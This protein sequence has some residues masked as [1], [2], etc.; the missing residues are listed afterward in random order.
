LPGGLIGAADAGRSVIA[1]ATV[2][3]LSLAVYCTTWTFYGSVGRAAA[4][5]IGFLP[6]YLGPTLMLALGWF[7]LHK[8]VR[9]AKANRITSIA[10]FVA[11][12]YGKSHLLGG[13]VTVIA[14]GWRSA[15]HR[16]PAQRRCPTASPFCCIILT[17]PCAATGRSPAARQCALCGDRHG[18]VYHPLWYPPP[19]CHR[20]SRG[21]VA[22]I[23]FESVVKLIAFFAVGLFVT[24]SLHDGLAAI[25]DQAELVPRLAKLMVAGDSA[26]NYGSW[27]ALTFLS[28][29]SVLLLPRQF[30]IAVVEN[31]NPDHLRPRVWLFPSTCFL[32]N[33]FV[34]P[35]ALGG[36]L[37]FPSGVD[38]DTF[39]LTLPM[40]A[41]G[42][43]LALFVFIAASRRLLAWSWWK[44]LPCP[45]WSA[46]DW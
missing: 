6:I 43:S 3:S 11:S 38:A 18:G 33:I 32:I 31:V 23:A 37:R 16:S 27:A 14:V 36:L 24:Y 20:A 12:R 5:G 13:L 26:A 10:D 41:Q 8:M 7:V 22:A 45:P 30:Q 4:T 19:R 15:L 28:M 1:N 9:V 25:F 44:P 17:S 29:L 42:E 21:H 35:I 40:A 46:N 34:L 2:Y 39:V